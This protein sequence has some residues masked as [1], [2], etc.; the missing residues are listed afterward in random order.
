MIILLWQVLRAR[1][2]C[3]KLLCQHFCW[4][5]Y[6]LAKLIHSTAAFSLDLRIVEYNFQLANLCE[7]IPGGLLDMKYQ[8]CFDTP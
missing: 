8:S 3:A 7:K 1:A 4:K 2:N 5:L 6:C